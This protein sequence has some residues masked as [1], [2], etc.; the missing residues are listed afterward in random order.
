[1]EL[2]VEDQ[3]TL[4]SLCED[5]INQTNT[6]ELEGFIID[7]KLKERVSSIYTRM[8]FSKG[9]SKLRKLVEFAVDELSQL[10]CVAYTSIDIDRKSELTGITFFA[11]D[12]LNPSVLIDDTTFFIDFIGEEDDIEIMVEDNYIHEDEF[13]DYI[14]EEAKE[15]IK[16]RFE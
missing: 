14:R 13:E 4:L 3:D 9:K 12:F 6:Q 1:M 16:G 2:T 5:Y 15:I 10:D 8:S 7:H 11:D